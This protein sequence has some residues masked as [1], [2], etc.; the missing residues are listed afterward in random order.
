M[1]LGLGRTQ[2]LLKRLGDPQLALRGVLIGGTNGKG[3]TQ[4]L[5]GSALRAAGY[6]VGQMPKPHLV[7]YRERILLDGEPISVA[8]FAG[9]IERVNDAA[10][11]VEARSG[12]L[13]EFELLTAAAFLWFA[14]QAVEVGV[15]E[16]GIGGR[17]D[18]TNVWQGGVSAIT[19]VALDHM[20]VLGD[21]VAAIAREKAQIIKRGDCAAV[22]GAAE[23]ALAVIRR[24]AARVKVPLAVV[25][26]LAISR[27]DWH[28][29]QARLPDGRE[30]KIGLLGRHQAANA[31]VAWRVL[32]ALGECAI[33][34]VDDRRRAAG[35]AAARWPGRLELLHGEGGPDVLLD[36]AHNPD[37][38]AALA[39]S[40]ADLLPA[41]A[42]PLTLLIGVIAN[43]WQPGM[44]DPLRVAV[45]DARVF[46]TCVP[47]TANSMP[48]TELAAAWGAAASAIEDPAAALE[49]AL[50]TAGAAGGLLLVCGSLYL[51]GH[52]R[53]LL[54]A[55]G[56]IATEK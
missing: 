11:Q 4:A 54:S 1:R 55:R 31:A 37:G 14:E 16:V 7:T 9:L 34:S 56:L 5:V 42:A 25:E 30:L 15:V 23:P 46:T 32:D 39:L 49:A 13:T 29:L 47:G 48:A 51:V 53:G 40:L 8:D 2:A 20:D 24:R 38:I 33:A 6:R 3:S 18:A 41:P 28:G 43:H 21:S 45:P 12:P 44:L 36:G 27:L 52:L 17:L 50:Q 26:P 19:G 22:T 35:F 10:D